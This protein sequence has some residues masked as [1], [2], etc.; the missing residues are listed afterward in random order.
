MYIKIYIQSTLLCHR[1]STSEYDIYF[2]LRNS[3]VHRGMI[4]SCIMSSLEY[5]RWKFSWMV[6]ALKKRKRNG[7]N[8]CGLYY[9]RCTSCAG[10]RNGYISVLTRQRHVAM[11]PR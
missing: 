8:D 4:F 11:P 2:I 7:W 1:P 9:I 5:Q 3:K 6:K 10:W